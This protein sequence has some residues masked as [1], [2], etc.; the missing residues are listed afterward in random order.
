MCSSA[1]P[2]HNKMNILSAFIYRRY[3]PAYYLVGSHKRAAT[4]ASGG[5]AECR[6]GSQCSLTCTYM[7][8]TARASAQ[9]FSIP[10]KLQPVQLRTVIMHASACHCS[11]FRLHHLIAHKAPSTGCA[12]VCR[13]RQQPTAC[14]M[15]HFRRVIASWTDPTLGNCS[16]LDTCR[17]MKTCKYIHYELDDE[18]QQTGD[19]TKSKHT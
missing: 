9:T 2:A 3:C 5:V 15:L 4:L 6:A 17:H 18:T 8:S 14:D 12:M 1:L 16:Y 13:A 19:L 7:A 11:Q 10:A